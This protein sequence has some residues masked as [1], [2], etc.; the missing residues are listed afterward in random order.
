MDEIRVSAKLAEKLG[1]DKIN[2]IKGL[3]DFEGM[4]RET[5][6]EDKLDAPTREII[7][8]KFQKIVDI[9]NNVQNITSK[10]IS[11]E[12]KKKQ[13]E[14]ELGDTKELLSGLSQ[15]I[16]DVKKVLGKKSKNIAHEIDEK[17]KKA[18]QALKN[19]VQGNIDIVKESIK[20]EKEKMN[21]IF[22][23]IKEKEAN[24]KQNLQLTVYKP[25]GFGEKIKNWWNKL[26]GK[27]LDS[28]KVPTQ[29]IDNT[30][31][32]VAKNAEEQENALYNKQVMANEHIRK[33]NDAYQKL[34]NDLKELNTEVANTRKKAMEKVR[35]EYDKAVASI[36]ATSE[37]V[38]EVSNKVKEMYNSKKS[39]K[40]EERKANR[41]NDGMDR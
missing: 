15:E 2:A 30:E 27:D 41:R 8:Q 14:Q 34:T 17:I 1:E 11:N 21:N 23:E 10:H 35:L 26:R 5:M 16:E 38:K 18:G 4:L 22:A 13:I 25:L 9:L 3:I 36:E 6:E 37:V 39:E 7:M 12:E 40:L 32:E 33:F 29:T 28:S 20:A 19:T 31:D 24:I